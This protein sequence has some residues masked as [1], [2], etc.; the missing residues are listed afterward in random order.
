MQQLLGSMN[1]SLEFL[2]DH[3][4]LK[5]LVVLLI[6]FALAR[7]ISFLLSRLLGGLVKHGFHHL[8]ESIT[9]LLRTPL[10]W[11]VIAFGFLLALELAGPPER[12]LFTLRSIILSL[13]LVAW[14]TFAVR[15]TRVIMQNM[16]SRHGVG[17]VIRQHTLPLFNN[18]ALVTVISIAGYLLFHIW[19]IDM[20]AWLASA[21]IVGIAV[22]FAAK[23]TLANLF[24]G[25]F[26]LADAPYKIGDYIVLE[27]TQRGKVTN[28]GL[29]STR[30]LTRDDVEVTVPNSVIGNS[31]VINESGGPHVK[32]RVRVPIGVAYGSDIDLV[33]KVL[34]DIAEAND[35]VCRDPEHRVRFRNFGPSAL[36]FE[37]LCWIEDPELRGRAV[38]A[39]NCAIYQKFIDNHIEIPYAKRDVYIKGWPQAADGSP[40]DRPDQP[41]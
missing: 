41:D 15:V 33:R 28:I 24:A 10:Y 31:S 37:L 13:L 7:F 40:A 29:R 32:Y 19:N 8:H 26:I 20:T 17:H 16:S 27:N 25:A 3:V 35:Q 22:G 34:M 9:R 21:G 14:S 1:A 23:D 6:A 5:A 12:I 36:E 30:I 2:G 38:D 11:T 39:L 4:Y 18:I